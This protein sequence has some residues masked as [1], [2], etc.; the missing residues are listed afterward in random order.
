M[1][2]YSIGVAV[3][4][5]KD[6]RHLEKCLPPLLKSPL[7]P[8]VLVFDSSSNDGTPE[9]AK[10]LGAEVLVVPRTEMNHGAARELCRKKLKTDIVV[11]MTPDAYAA[12]S[13][14]LTKLIEPIVSG[15]AAVSYARQIA[16]AGANIISRFGR[17]F[18][19]PD[20]SNIRSIK[21]TSTYGVYTAFCSDACTA[22]LNKALDEIGGFRWVLS[23]EDAVAAAMLLRK[24]YKIAYVAEAVV[25]HSHN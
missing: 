7:K 25:E 14:M 2:K 16:N 10:K 12:D 4:T 21:D 3:I 22:W 1:T 9:L 15:K 6:A 5:Y 18:N 8:K 13:Q 19:F 23:G 11:M 24:G 17:Q 20:K